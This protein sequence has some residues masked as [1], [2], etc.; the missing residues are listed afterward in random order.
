MELEI[1]DKNLALQELHSISDRSADELAQSQQEVE[2]LRKQL[3]V[4]KFQQQEESELAPILVNVIGRIV[5]ISQRLF[6]GPVTFDYSFDPENPSD[7]YLVFDVITRGEFADYCDREYA[8]HEEVE[9]V[10]PG[11]L[12]EFRLCVMPQ[13]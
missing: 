4:V 5:E 3:A 6:P 12:C 8:W 7:E 10:V 1:G 13:R 11:A 2:R 9:K